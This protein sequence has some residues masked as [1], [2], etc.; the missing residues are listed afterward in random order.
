MAVYSQSAFLPEGNS[1]FGFSG[2]YSTDENTHG[3]GVGVAFCFS[4]IVDVGIDFT[5]GEAK[6][7]SISAIIL[8]PFIR[9]FLLRQKGTMPIS[10]SLSADYVAGTYDNDV[11]DEFGL[12]VTSAGI[13]IGGT[14][15]KKFDVSPSFSIMPTVR[16]AYYTYTLSLEDPSGFFPNEEGKFSIPSLGAGLS[17]IADIDKSV[18]FSFVTSFSLSEDSIG[19]GVGV[20]LY[21]GFSPGSV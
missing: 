15:Y 17:L 18:F 11:I 16:V 9:V 5:N 20:A 12:D 10:F 4:G 8:S 2:G 19:M 14:I 1:G 7:D 3:V 6:D 21:Y 13:S